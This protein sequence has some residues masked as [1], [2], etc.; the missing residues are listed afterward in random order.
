[1]YKMNELWLTCVLGCLEKEFVF[2]FRM[3]KL[4]D[5][6]EEAIGD[7]RTY[8][9]KPKL[10]N[11]EVVFDIYMLLRDGYLLVDTIEWK[12]YWKYKGLTLG[13]E[14][15]TTTIDELFPGEDWSFISNVPCARP[16]HYIPYGGKFEDIYWNYAINK[17]LGIT[18]KFM[19]VKVIY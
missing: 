7:V 5:T 17:D 11:R 13:D 12:E 4:Y 1:M 15:N 2:H 6:P 3:P 9:I 10:V 18:L 19:D 14:S 16:E 8:K